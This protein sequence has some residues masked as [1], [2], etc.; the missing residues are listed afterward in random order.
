MPGHCSSDSVGSHPQDALG[1]ECPW[2]DEWHPHARGEADANTSGVSH[3][4]RKCSVS[5]LWR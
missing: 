2:S 4:D 5:C 1:L 3:P